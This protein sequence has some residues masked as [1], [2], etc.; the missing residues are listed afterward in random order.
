MTSYGESPHM[1]TRL[2]AR[3]AG[4]VPGCSREMALTPEPACTQE[5]HNR[6][7]QIKMLFFFN[8]EVFMYG[9]AVLQKKD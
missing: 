6:Q 3:A 8:R 7:K 9:I 2:D 1:R 5:A 4:E